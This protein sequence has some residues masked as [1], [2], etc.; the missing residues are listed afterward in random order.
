MA[1][2]PIV[3]IVDVVER[4]TQELDDAPPRSNRT[5]ETGELQQL[6][7]PTHGLKRPP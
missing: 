5:P 3:G 1:E 7:L 4:P 6:R 2:Q